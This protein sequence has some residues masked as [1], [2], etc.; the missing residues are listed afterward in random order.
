MSGANQWFLN[1]ERERNPMDPW[2]WDYGDSW[3]NVSTIYYVSYAI[4]STSLDLIADSLWDMF[5]S[6]IFDILYFIAHEITTTLPTIQ[7][8]TSVYPVLAILFLFFFSSNLLINFFVINERLRH[9]MKLSDEAAKTISAMI[10]LIAAF[11]IT[12]IMIILG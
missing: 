8:S 1:Y 5:W 4:L 11:T 10:S 12:V 2:D 3:F 6:I 7:S 9:V